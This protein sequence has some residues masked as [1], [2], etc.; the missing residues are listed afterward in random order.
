ML[1]RSHAMRPERWHGSL[2]LSAQDSVALGPRNTDSVIGES[3]G[4]PVE[5]SLVQHSRVLFSARPDQYEGY[6]RQPSP[7]DR[8]KSGWGALT[9][10]VHHGQGHWNFRRNRTC[11]PHESIVVH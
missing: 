3:V 2:H 8:P 6:R 7:R 10:L 11:L 1:T 4:L 9:E 5:T